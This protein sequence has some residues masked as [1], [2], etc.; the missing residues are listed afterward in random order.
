MEINTTTL[1]VTNKLHVNLALIAFT[2][3]DFELESSMC[4][5]ATGVQSSDRVSVGSKT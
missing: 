1:N 3:E 4:R 5:N 2:S